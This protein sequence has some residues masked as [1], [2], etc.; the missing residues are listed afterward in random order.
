MLST[1]SFILNVSIGGS[2]T[3]GFFDGESL[4]TSRSGSAPSPPG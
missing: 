4:S 1:S 2:S 3:R